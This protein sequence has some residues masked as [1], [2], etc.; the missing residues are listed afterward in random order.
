MGSLLWHLC[1]LLALVETAARPL[2]T[3]YLHQGVGDGEVEASLLTVCSHVD[4]S[5]I[6]PHVVVFGRGSSDALAPALAARNCSVA[7]F[8]AR[9]RDAGGRIA[10]EDSEVA[11]LVDHVG[12]RAGQRRGGRRARRRRARRIVVRRPR[13]R[14]HRGARR[15]CGDAVRRQEAPG[16]HRVARTHSHEHAKRDPA[17]VQGAPVREVPSRAGPLGL[18]ARERE[19]KEVTQQTV[20]RPPRRRAPAGARPRGARP[21]AVGTTRARR[22]A[23]SR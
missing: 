16:A 5:R 11:R 8:P 2:K 7:R 3:A 9:W 19:A 17:G 4:R 18:Q 10:W 1:W 12:R 20:T 23:R 15:L 6:D 13:P 14:H 22:R 21:G